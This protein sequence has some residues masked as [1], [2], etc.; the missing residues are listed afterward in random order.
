MFVLQELYFIFKINNLKIINFPPF[1]AV[2]TLGCLCIHRRPMD[3]PVVV[4]ASVGWANCG[5]FW[6]FLMKHVCKNI[7]IICLMLF[8]GKNEKKLAF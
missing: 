1:V 6:L 2:V 3:S 8:H 7:L 5:I 4:S